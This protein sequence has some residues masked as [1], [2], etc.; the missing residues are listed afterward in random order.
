MQIDRC[1][2]VYIQALYIPPPMLKKSHLLFKQQF[3][4]PGQS[5]CVHFLITKRG[6][7]PSHDDKVVS[8]LLLLI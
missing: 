5:F 7:S 3:S 2:T 8:V 4:S 1:E 6:A